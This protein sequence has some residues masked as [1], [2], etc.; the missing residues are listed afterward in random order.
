MLVFPP[1][2]RPLRWLPRVRVP[3]WHQVGT[4]GCTKS[5][6]KGWGQSKPKPRDVNTLMC[7][8]GIKMNQVVHAFSLVHGS[9][10]LKYR[11]PQK[12]SEM[13]IHWFQF[14]SRARTGSYQWCGCETPA[15]DRPNAKRTTLGPRNLGKCTMPPGRS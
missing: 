1:H 11:D 8:Y 14:S 3:A 15:V 13:Q 6:S 10:P 2:R 4:H 5:V 7:C 12:I 9:G